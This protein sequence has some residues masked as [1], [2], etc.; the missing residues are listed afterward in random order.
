MKPL[1]GRDLRAPLRSVAGSQRHADLPLVAEWVEGA[2]FED[3]FAR[4]K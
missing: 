2:V 4:N 3:A 1:L